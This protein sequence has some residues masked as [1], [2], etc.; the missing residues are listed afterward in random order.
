MFLTFDHYAVV[1]Q[2]QPVNMPG[3]Q[4]PLVY[5]SSSPGVAFVQQPV[6]QQQSL[7]VN[8]PGQ[9]QPQSMYAASAPP[10]GFV[11][12]PVAAVPGSFVQQPFTAV[13]ANFVN[14]VS[15]SAPQSTTGESG[16]PE[17]QFAPPSTTGVE[18]KSEPDPASDTAQHHADLSLSY[19]QTASDEFH[20]EKNLIETV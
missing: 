12:Q 14:P 17:P 16:V 15:S 10:V 18:Q 8:I 3:Q 13:P 4:Q 19:G 5:A 2:T 7:P 1:Q 11:Q 9:Q 20:D 6:G